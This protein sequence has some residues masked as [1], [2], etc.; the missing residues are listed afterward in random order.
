MDFAVR[1]PLVPRSRLIS[2][3]CSSTRV[4]APRFLQTPPHG[5]SPCALLT[6]HLHQ[7]GWKTF[8]SELLN[9]LGTRRILQLKSEIRNRRLDWCSSRF[10]ESDLRFRISD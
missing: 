10:A 8:T 3:S 9:M 5:D 4:V 2:G 1:R 6:L 7:V